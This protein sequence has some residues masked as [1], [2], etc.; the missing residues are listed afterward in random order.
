[1]GPKGSL[2][3]HSSPTALTESFN[4]MRL[5]LGGLAR[6]HGVRFLDCSRVFDS[7]KVTAEA[8]VIKN[9]KVFAKIAHNEQ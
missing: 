3:P 8:Q 5:G 4:S 1:M 6:T 7:E 2:R 9:P